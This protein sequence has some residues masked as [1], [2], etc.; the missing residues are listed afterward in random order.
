[1]EGDAGASRLNPTLAP[2]DD[3]LDSGETTLDSA[4][5]NDEFAPGVVEDPGPDSRLA[6]RGWVVAGCVVLL[7]L[8]ALIAGGGLLATIAGNRA[9][10]SRGNE[11]AAVQAAKDCVIAT[12][13]PDAAAMAASQRKIIECSTGDFAAQAALYSG[14]LVDAYAAA[15]AQVQV[16]NIRAAV[17]RH[18][19]DGS[20]DVLVALRVKMSNANI[21]DQESG[22]RLRVQMAPDGGTYKIARL[23][24]VT[25]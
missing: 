23:D 20:M 25:K 9:G 11:A 13:A 19:D 6:T 22:Y 24:Q 17:E 8:S 16:S 5:S 21:S 10:D 4:A 2:E 15:K 1:M 7:L 18:N 3:E 12:Q 14:V